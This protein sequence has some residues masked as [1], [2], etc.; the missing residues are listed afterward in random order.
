MRPMTK[1]VLVASMLSWLHCG[2]TQEPAGAIRDVQTTGGSSGGGSTS[3]GAAGG[4]GGTTGGVDPEPDAGDE[5]DCRNWD[6]GVFAFDAGVTC[7]PGLIMTQPDAGRTGGQ[8]WLP[9]VDAVCPLEGLGYTCLPEPAV[10]GP[11]CVD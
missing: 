9:C 1:A 2:G 7:C 8:C 3:G 10:D 4:L 5:T 6:G 11:V